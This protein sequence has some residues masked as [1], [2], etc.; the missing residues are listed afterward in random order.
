VTDRARDLLTRAAARNPSD[1]TAHLELA[2]T[3]EALGDAPGAIREYERAL[4]LD[5]QLDSAQRS[6][7]VL[8]GRNGQ[9]G[10]GFYHLATAARLEGDYPTALNQYHR[11]AQL[12]PAGAARADDT[13]QWI[14]VLSD[15]LHVSLPP[16][17]AR[18]A[19]D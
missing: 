9:E 4:E 7:G 2:R 11:A 19:A 12:L 10:D 14:A 13:Q 17:P 6:L 8:A 1:A 15:Y 16:T 18:H 3:L 5:P